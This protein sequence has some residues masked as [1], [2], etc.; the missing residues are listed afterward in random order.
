MLRLLPALLVLLF[1]V[2]ALAEVLDAPT[3]GIRFADPLNGMTITGPTVHIELEV[4]DFIM[5]AGNAVS[6]PDEYANGERRANTGHYHV[7]V[8][9]LDEGLWPETYAFTGAG[10]DMAF[11]LDLPNGT[12]QL[13]ATLQ[14]DDH[15][16]RVM[17]GPKDWPALAVT[18]IT[19]VPEPASLALLGMGGA[20]LLMRRRRCR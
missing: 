6:L 16:L 18:T 12:Y 14:Y 20:V 19:V 11:D 10:N 13:M 17:N 2:P 8:N 5:D 3:P 4:R 7:Y 1:A 15:T 9:R